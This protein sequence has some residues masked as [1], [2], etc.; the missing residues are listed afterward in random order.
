MEE[1][2][3]EELISSK[4]TLKP[5]RNF[6]II[7]LFI[8]ILI[9]IISI[10]VII[11][12][13]IKLNN[14]SKKYDELKEK[15][16]EEKNKN[17]EV[18]E[19]LNNKTEIYKKLEEKYSKQN[20]TLNNM[21][22]VFQNFISDANI[23]NI[24]IPKEKYTNVKDVVISSKGLKDGTYDF[25]TKEAL[26]LKE[27]YQV[28]FETYSRNS[29]NFYS[30]EEYNNI[31]YKLSC[32]IGSNANIGVYEDNPHISFYVKD[33]NTSLSLAALFNQKTIW[34][35]NSSGLILNTFH[36]PKFY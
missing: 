30:D 3:S 31:V 21:L 8:T 28:S 25:V 22:E 10:V 18:T 16:S 12:L 34:D 6:N 19:E 36:Q 4:I 13:I 2:F 9:F 17:I 15:Y 23:S 24:E 35:W 20:D 5:K 29:E 32:L 26:Y 33:L 11:V 7:L 27:G 14:K 1:Q